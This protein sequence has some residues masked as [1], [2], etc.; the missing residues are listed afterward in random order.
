MTARSLLLILLVVSA[1]AGFTTMRQRPTPM[2]SGGARAK[3]SP[4]AQFP[5]HLALPVLSYVGLGATT[6]G[7][8]KLVYG[9]MA[10]SN[11]WFPA[12]FVGGAVALPAAMLSFNLMANG[13]PGVAK[14]MGGKPANR[15]LTRLANEAAEAVGVPAPAH[16]FEI[17]AKEPNAFAAAGWRGRASTVA[18]TTGLRDL[19]TADELSAVLA[20]EMGHLQHKDV[21]SNMHVAV[22]IAGM[23]GIHEAGRLLLRLSKSER[24]S[25]KKNKDDS[26]GAAGLGVA[27]M[28]LGLGSQAVAHGLRLAASRGAEFAADHAA[29][30][31]FG[32]DNMISALKKI[33]GGSRTRP[34][35]LRA[36]Y[37]GRRMAFAMINGESSGAPGAEN[38]SPGAKRSI[39]SKIGRAFRTH[40]PMDERIT[41]LETAVKDGSVPAQK[42]TLATWSRWY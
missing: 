21:E 1:Q 15:W 30:T 29:A 22:A 8:L 23:S 12:A 33:E 26:S 24:K 17:P 4:A 10:A 39:W 35:D 13:G 19:L 25:S 5:K 31:A 34:A 9:T 42:E 40:P 20:H 37:S 16:V 11:A 32:A 7:A 36:T 2:P 38:T 27:L 28:G 6:A 18:V 3:K 41:A 14:S